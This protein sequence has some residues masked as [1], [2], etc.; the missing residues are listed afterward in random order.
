M[1]CLTHREF[2]RYCRFLYPL[3]SRCQTFF[4]L[5]LM[6]QFSLFLINKFHRSAIVVYP[7]LIKYKRFIIEVLRTYVYELSVTQEK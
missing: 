2:Y 6:N 1:N 3:I 5:L 4:N 7:A